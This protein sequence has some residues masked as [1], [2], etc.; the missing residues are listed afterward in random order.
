MAATA[1]HTM[2]AVDAIWLHMDRPENLL[3]IDTLMWFD[4][5]VDERRLRA[6]LAERLVERFP[7]F[8]MRPAEP[9]LPLGSPR[10]ETDPTAARLRSPRAA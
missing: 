1:R 4:G 2:G 10:W 6:V 5:R 3:V 8:G 7:V 9:L